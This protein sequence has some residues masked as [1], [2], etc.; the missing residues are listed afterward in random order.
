MMLV[1]PAAPRSQAILD[2]EVVDPRAFG[3]VIGD[4]LRR[5]VHLSL[6]AGYQLENASL[7]KAGRLNR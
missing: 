3:Y 1:C 4:T 6:R 2:V 5:E 7:P